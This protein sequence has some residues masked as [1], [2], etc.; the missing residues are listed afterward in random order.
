MADKPIKSK[1]STVGGTPMVGC[2]SLA[3]K[4][5]VALAEDVDIAK[6]LH[7]GNLK[8]LMDKYMADVQSGKAD[9]I[10]NAKEFVEVIKT[11]MLLMG[12]ATERVETQDDERLKAI[13]SQIDMDNPEISSL[14][15]AMFASMNDVNNSYGDNPSIVY[16]GEG[17]EDDELPSTTDEINEEQTVTEEYEVREDGESAY[18][19]PDAREQAYEDYMEYVEEYDED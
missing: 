14:I 11:D 13:E 2:L 6:Q 3:F 10:R 12:E 5:A 8:T 16:E 7:R 1:P 9:G 4:K 15:S 17:D 18:D 19:N